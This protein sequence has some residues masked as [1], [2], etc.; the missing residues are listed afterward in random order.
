M[1]RRQVSVTMFSDELFDELAE[2]WVARRAEIGLSAAQARRAIADGR[3]L[4][5]LRRQDVDV[6]LA[7]DDAVV[8][9]Y[10]WVTGQSLSTLLDT[11]SVSVEELYVVPEHRAHGVAKALLT[12]CAAHAR[13]VGAEQVVCAVPT[14][15]REANRTLARLGFAPSITRRVAP[16][17]L[18]LRRL[19][20][21]EAPQAEATVLHRRRRARG[22]GV[23]AIG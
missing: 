20:G 18:L 2:V 11:P 9:G 10:A 23:A 3:L 16:T 12:A 19:R 8:V 21:G 13:R 4:R 1:A 15:A 22:R 6:F 14:R 5:T 7:V 17:A